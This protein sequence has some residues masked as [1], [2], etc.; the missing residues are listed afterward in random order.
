MARKIASAARLLSCLLS[1]WT[2]NAMSAAGDP[3]GDEAHLPAG[4][5]ILFCGD[6][7]TGHGTNLA[8]GFVHR[9]EQ[10]LKLV[11][12]EA[13]PVLASLGGSGQTVGSWLNIEKQSRTRDIGALDSKQFNV[14]QE[15]AEHA[16]ALVIMLGMND[17]LS[18][19][20]G[21][22]DGDVEKWAD[23]YREL[24]ATLRERVKPAV[25]VLCTPTPCT[26]D[27]LSPKNLLMERMSVRLRAL[28]AEMGCR[29]GDAGEQCRALL[30]KG[31]MLSPKFHLAGDYVHPGDVGHIGI[32]VGM[33][34]GLGYR[35]AAIK[36]AEEALPALWNRASG[37]L[38]DISWQ[39]R[40]LSDARSLPEVAFA[41]NYFCNF[42]G[43]APAHV[44]VGIKTPAGWRA[45]PGTGNG[46]TGEFLLRTDSFPLRATCLLTAKTSDG[47]TFSREVFIAAPWVA[48][49]VGPVGGWGHIPTAPVEP[50]KGPLDDAAAAGGG[51][52][53]AAARLKAPPRWTVFLPTV[54]YTGQDDPGNVDFCGVSHAAPFEM[55]YAW[56]TVTSEK[57]REARLKLS[58][59]IFAGKVFV[60]VWLN[61]EQVFNGLVNSRSATA[62]IRL[63]EGRNQLV[64]KSS[65]TSWQWQQ[66]VEL[67]A[68]DGDTLEGCRISLQ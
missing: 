39:V 9:V 54:D 60:T 59:Q 63:R 33:L 51:L 61:G 36:L 25:T 55:G 50:P 43:P 56:R 32:A 16:D 26:E 37:A 30:A 15:L 13:K 68:A 49:T 53:A 46:V 20:M 35:T 67:E 21:D 2:A 4:A 27:M 64:V 18:P 66:R 12:P 6:S 22:G 10:A 38:P 34:N 45:E 57:D 42:E 44:Q 62:V 47:R 1:L 5:R 14:Q 3:A 41:V 40:R 17:V 52:L 65:H 7:I 28:A 48:G 8:G 23:R 24:I 58:S 11:D 29:V 19:S 31:R